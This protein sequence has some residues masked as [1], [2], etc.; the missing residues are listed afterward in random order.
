MQD[1]LYKVV[2]RTSLGTG[3]GVVVLREGRLCGGDSGLYFVGTYQVT[4]SHFTADLQIDRH[5]QEPGA[6]PLFGI[7]RLVVRLDGVGT[8]DEAV[9]R[10]TS[11]DAPGIEFEAVMT[12]LSD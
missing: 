4:G 10:G 2:F 5:T 3:G 6:R 12:K 11:P 7:S 8:G 9:M 1:G